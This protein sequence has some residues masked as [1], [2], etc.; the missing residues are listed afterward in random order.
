MTPSEQFTAAAAQHPGATEHDEHDE[1]DQHIDHDM[2]DHDREEEQ[3][4]DEEEVEDPTLDALLGDRILSTQ[5]SKRHFFVGTL[6]PVTESSDPAC[7]DTV[8]NTRSSETAAVS[9]SSA[10]GTD[11]APMDMG[12]AVIA[13]TEQAASTMGAL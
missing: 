2:D 4:H 11:G 12:T 10:F 13:G 9:R 3:E 7:I 8:V 5:P 1:D 6:E